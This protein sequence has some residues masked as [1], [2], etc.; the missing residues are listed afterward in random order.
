MKIYTPIC[1]SL[2]MIAAASPLA[3]AES[4]GFEPGRSAAGMD[5]FIGFVKPDTGEQN[6]LS[7]CL[8][9]GDRITAIA[10]QSDS[11]TLRGSPGSQGS[12]SAA[13]AQ[14]ALWSWLLGPVA[15]ADENATIDGIS[16][17]FIEGSL[18]AETLGAEFPGMIPNLGSDDRAVSVF[19][20]TDSYQIINGQTV[21]VPQTMHTTLIP[22]PSTAA[23]GLAGLLVLGARRRG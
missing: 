2:G 19:E 11:T 4:V 5:A 3:L 13:A 18:D 21:F 6:T 7:F 17:W 15:A 12:V 20:T 14:T 8:R 10:V 16:I 1:A 23:L 22:L 9:F